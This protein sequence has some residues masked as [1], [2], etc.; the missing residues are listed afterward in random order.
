MMNSTAPIDIYNAH[1]GFH[2]RPFTLV[3]DPEFLYWSRSHRLAFT[4]LEYGVVT[5][6]PI[7]VITGEVGAGKTTLLQYLLQSVPDDVIVGLISNAQGGRGELLQWV[8]HS[9]GVQF[10]VNASYVML[11]QRLQDFLLQT[12]A[13]GSRV[14]LIIDEAQNLS[15]ET[16]EELRML[17]NINS[18]K[19]ELVQ[20]VL[21]GQP[22]LRDLVSRPDLSQFAQRVGASFHLTAMSPES[23]VE[24]IAHRLRIAGG[25]GEE[26]TPEAAALIYEVT[27]GVPRLVNKL[28]DLALVY[29]FSAN[30]AQVTAETIDAVL[31][32][33]VFFGNVP[34][35][36]DRR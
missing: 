32:D 28:C 10:D 16:L 1:F 14:I 33:G 36:E 26:F 24:Y 25:N 29:T 18:N 4:M 5:R 20:L 19:D 2:E 23:V 31:N 8:L 9:L 22:E 11:F 7:T 15:I 12:Y 34:R 6:A 13:E 30:E 27:G 3:P 17:T 21:V 35:Q